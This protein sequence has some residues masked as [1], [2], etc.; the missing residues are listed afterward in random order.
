LS[1]FLQ[2]D[3]AQS[4]KIIHVL[5]VVPHYWQTEADANDTS[6]SNA[7]TSSLT[8]S[9]QHR[10]ANILIIAQTEDDQPPGYTPPPAYDMAWFDF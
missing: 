6:H 2:T 3:E 10:P 5:T 4:G 8:P 7:S 9:R 1:R